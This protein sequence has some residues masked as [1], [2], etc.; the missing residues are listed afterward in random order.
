MAIDTK[1]VS[2]L[3]TD[4]RALKAKD[5][6]TPESLGY[7]LQRLADLLATA[8][9]S[10]TIAKIQTLLEGF[11]IAGY[12]ITNIKQGAADR[13]NVNAVIDKLNLGT[14]EV[15]SSSGIL[16][17]QATTE[18]AGAMRAQQVTDLNNARTGVATLQ[19]QMKQAEQSIEEIASKLGATSGKGIYNTAQISCFVKTNRLHV[20]GAQQLIADGYVP[21]IFRPIRKR[22]QFKDNTIKIPNGK[23]YCHAT[24]G[25]SVYGSMYSV[26]I[27]N[28]EVQFTTQDH[29]LLSQPATA[30]SSAAQDFVSRHVNKDGDTTF[31]WGRS[32]VILRDRKQQDRRHRMIRLRFG[33]G[34]AKPIHPGRAKITSANLV[35]SLAEFSIIYDSGTRTWRFGHP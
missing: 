18:R 28:T 21:Y 25:W 34:F 14:G 11:R 20:I 26:R 9:N 15:T 17:Q 27:A 22:N 7:I 35:S 4:F 2:Q 29:G 1:S 16:L 6:I 13:N 3:I 33:I 10:E 31:G 30:Y 5:S 8:G 12:A 24:K 19:K 23:K 32:S